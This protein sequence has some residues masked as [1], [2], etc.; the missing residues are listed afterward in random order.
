MKK[1]V[2]FLLLFLLA[3][4]AFAQNFNTL[5]NP[6]T[7]INAIPF[8]TTATR[9]LRTI[10]RTA[11]FITA[12]SSGLITTLYMASA[13]GS[14]SGTWANFQI[15]L[16]QTTDTVLTNTTFSSGLTLVLNAASF[17]IPFVTSNG[18]FAL[19]LT[20]PFNSSNT[21]GI[22][23][24]EAGSREVLD[25]V[26]INGHNFSIRSGVSVL[27]F[28]GTV[29][30]SNRASIQ[31]I[32]TALTSSSWVTSETVFLSS[33]GSYNT[34]LAFDPA[35]YNW[36]LAGNSTVLDSGRTVSL[37]PSVS[38]TYVLSYSDGFCTITDSFEVNIIA[39]DLSI[40]SFVTPS[41]N[42]TVRDPV[43]VKVWVKNVGSAPYQGS[44]GVRY[45]V[46]NGLPT[47]AVNVNVNLTAG[48]STEVT[49]TPNWI[50][51]PAG[52]YTLCAL[53]DAV[54][55]DQNQANDTLCVVLNSAVSVEDSRFAQ[56]GLYPNP[57]NERVTLTGLPAG[58]VV[59]V[60]NMQGQ[61]IYTATLD[62]ASQLQLE[63]GSWQAGLYQIS[64]QA[65]GRYASRKLMVTR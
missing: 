33:I 52:A 62:Q 59:E 36:R 43:E 25:A 17:S 44:V 22:W 64:I 34:T 10:Y 11:D 65:E 3:E 28:M 55:S 38:G 53:L 4:G 5:L 49:L 39:P 12:P 7:G 41:N 56:L 20:S 9:K 27:D 35:T 42:G 31:R 40:N 26:S 21:V 2:S 51:G 48:D 60:Q 46:N 54:S 23:M 14:G 13:S 1:V 50:P 18:Y 15:S 19:P 61:L 29:T 24:E 32:G 6:N 57:A 16:G 30:A 37:L 47:A 63:I 45:R 8:N 58:S